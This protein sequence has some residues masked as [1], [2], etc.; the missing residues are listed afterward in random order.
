LAYSDSDARYALI[1]SKSEDILPPIF[2]GLELIVNGV[3][4]FKLN[5][6]Y[7]LVD[8]KGNILLQNLYEGIGKFQD[9]LA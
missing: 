2:E 1:N 9:N 6:K 3:Y 4:K 8:S 5:G 7:G